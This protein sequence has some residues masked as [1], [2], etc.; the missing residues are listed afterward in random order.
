MFYKEFPLRVSSYFS[1]FLPINMLNFSDIT[2]SQMKHLKTLKGHFETNELTN[3]QPNTD[4]HTHNCTY[5]V[6]FTIVC[7]Y[8]VGIT[9]PSVTECLSHSNI[10]RLSE[11]CTFFFISYL[12]NR[13]TERK[14]TGSIPQLADPAVRNNK[15]CFNILPMAPN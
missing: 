13:K 12:L 15:I 9:S 11:N 6:L 2:G 3:V 5:S 4:T 8:N 14:K 10:P 7:H 1:H